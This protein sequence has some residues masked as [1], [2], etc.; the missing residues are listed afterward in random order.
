[1][2]IFTFRVVTFHIKGKG[3]SCCQAKSVTTLVDANRT[4][5]LSMQRNRTIVKAK[6]Y[7]YCQGKKV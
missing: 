4:Q 6:G 7:N 1:M 3:Y 5:H 2:V